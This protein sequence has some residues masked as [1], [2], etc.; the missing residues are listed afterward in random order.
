[1][2]ETNNQKL[3][4]RRVAAHILGIHP[5][6]LSEHIKEGKLKLSV[7]QVGGLMMFKESEV[8][9]LLNNEHKE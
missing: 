7:V 5:N 8:Q 2:E 3:I 1:M 4:R 9:A 6:T